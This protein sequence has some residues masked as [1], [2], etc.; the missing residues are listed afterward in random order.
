MGHLPC[1][2]FKTKEL[3]VLRASGFPNGALSTVM[4][5]QTELPRACSPSW[6][7]SVQGSRA[8]RGRINHNF[9]SVSE[10][11]NED[12]NHISDLV[13]TKKELD[14]REDILEWD[15]WYPLT[16]P[17]LTRCSLCVWHSTGCWGGRALHHSLSPEETHHPVGDAAWQ[18]I[19]TPRGETN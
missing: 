6:S 3:G 16:P 9:S 1:M 12:W 2:W 4:S 8:P 15:G 17:R 14:G 11:Q 5:V 10:R 13:L 19:I 18:M 7:P